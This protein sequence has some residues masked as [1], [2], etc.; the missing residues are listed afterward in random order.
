VKRLPDEEVKMNRSR[1][2]IPVVIAA[3]SFMAIAFC[4]YHATPTQAVVLK[5][6]PPIV[7]TVASN[8]HNPRGLNF[9]P[10]GYLY[11]AEAGGTGT[12]TSL[13][14]VM[15]DGSNKCLAYTG[16]IA[17][18]SNRTGSVQRIVSDLPSLISP[19]GT[20][21]GATGI[22]DISF[23][24][25]GD[26]D[27]VEGLRESLREDLLGRPSDGQLN[28]GFKGW[29]TIG[30]GG[31]PAWRIETFATQGLQFSRLATFDTNGKFRFDADPG[32]YEQAA[33]P[34]APDP[35]DT[36]PYGILALHDKVVFTDAGGN[37]LNQLN[38]NGLI[39]TLAV[40][41]RVNRPTSPPPNVQ[42]V[43]T[44][45]ALGPDGN[46]YVGVLT[47]GPFTVGI[48][49]VYRVPA[50]GGVPQ[51][52]Y[53]GFTNIIDLTFGPDGSLYVLEIARNAIPNFGA[54]GR[55]VRIAPNGSRTDI[56]SGP[57]LI[58]PG[59][60]AVGFDGSLYVTNMSTSGT[61]GTVLRIIP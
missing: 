23:A 61:S 1:I 49:S 33:N 19:D 15:G 47:G 34:D 14:R 45:V 36:N 38:P 30:F 40:F 8:L 22:H 6:P 25:S 32:I 3:L 56:I 7:F 43:P 50:G 39:S 54:G 13:C 31:D 10:D 52:A 4:L 12:P 20:A 53:S 44:S 59:G 21:Q 28:N 16:S 60:V 24:P 42:A 57:P 51:V 9:A 18:L 37:T 17:R 58:A 41:G 11:V 48:A 2:F 26:N 27:G 35:T 29:A 5:A 55:L 46:Y